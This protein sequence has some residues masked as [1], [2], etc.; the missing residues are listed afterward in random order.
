M[1]YSPFS[2]SHQDDLEDYDFSLLHA[3]ARLFPQSPLAELVE[4]YLAYVG[5]QVEEEGEEGGRTK[6][7]A[8]DEN[9]YIE[10]IMVRM[11]DDT[12]VL[13]H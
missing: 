6:P 2:Q 3:F 11:T 7:S 5:I 8:G 1:R 4:A 12:R 10:I 9:D 13:L